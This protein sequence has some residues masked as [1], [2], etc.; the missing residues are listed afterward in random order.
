M[1]K[2]VQICNYEDRKVLIV[3]CFFYTFV[4]VLVCGF[5]IVSRYN[6]YIYT[7]HP[8]RCD[9][10]FQNVANNILCYCFFL[11]LSVRE[12]WCIPPKKGFLLLRSR[13][14]SFFSLRF[15]RQKL[16]YFYSIWLIFS[17]FFFSCIF[18]ESRQFIYSCHN[19]VFIQV[20][21]KRLHK[22][23]LSLKVF[24][25]FCMV[26]WPVSLKFE[27]TGFCQLCLHNHQRRL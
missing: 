19:H 2:G 4:E 10:C 23:D 26:V 12:I 18:I 14:N 13:Y 17:I 27:L 15:R 6:I 25:K 16:F 8:L 1:S 5:K 21:V 22:E 24:S 9:W 7:R 20:T 11:V 3:C